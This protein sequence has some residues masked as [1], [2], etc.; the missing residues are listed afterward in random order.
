[1]EYNLLNLTNLQRYENNAIALSC[2]ER[3]IVSFKLD[4]RCALWTAFFF[5][6]TVSILT[7][8]SRPQKK[9]RQKISANGTRTNE[10]Q[11]EESIKPS[12]HQTFFGDFSL[13]AVPY[14]SS[15][16]NL[17]PRCSCGPP[18]LISSCRNR[19]CFAL[20]MT[21]RLMPR[22]RSLTWM[23]LRVVR[24]SKARSGEIPT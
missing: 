2:E 4:S 13:C 12:Y 15:A 10:Q 17:R 6:N 23:P 24:K 5:D 8:S 21:M 20:W 9:F 7:F 1:M 22:A 16:S 14:A 11:E 18:I 3:E 19:R